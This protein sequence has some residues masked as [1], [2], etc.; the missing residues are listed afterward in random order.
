[1]RF[2]SIDKFAHIDILSSFEYEYDEKEN[3]IKEIVYSED[4]SERKPFKITEREIVYY[5]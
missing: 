5:K 4:S 2:V 3:W 1:M